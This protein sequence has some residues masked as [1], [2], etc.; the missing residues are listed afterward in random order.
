MSESTSSTTKVKLLDRD[1]EVKCPPDKIADLQESAR[2][3]D[4]KMREV[5]HQG[6]IQSLDR[7][8]AIAALN[9]V[10]ELRT[11]KEQNHNYMDTISQRI[12]SLHNKI[13]LQRLHQ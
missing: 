13:E 3:L 2:Y 5:V 9:V 12:Q 10:H 4:G 8:A 7:V 11:Q 6:R 1:F